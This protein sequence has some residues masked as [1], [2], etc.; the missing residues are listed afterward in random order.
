MMDWREWAVFGV[1]IV[2]LVCFGI[3]VGTAIK[4]ARKN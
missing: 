2:F 4:H 1:F 3:V